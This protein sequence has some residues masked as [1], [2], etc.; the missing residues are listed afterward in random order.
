VDPAEAIRKCR[1]RLYDCHLKDIDSTAPGGKTPE[2]GRG[3]GL[4]QDQRPPA[5]L[6]PPRLATRTGRP[7][8]ARRLR[9]GGCGRG[10]RVSRREG[11][12]VGDV[13]T[14]AGG[15][16]FVRV[17]DPDGGRRVRAVRARSARG[18][19]QGDAAG[20]PADLVEA[21]P[22]WPDRRRRDGAADRFYKDVL[23]FSEIWR[24]GRNGT[25]TDWIKV[26]DGTDYL[27]YMLVTGP[28]DRDRLGSA[29]HVALL[30][31]DIQAALETVRARPKGLDPRSVRT[32]QVGRNR[33]WQ[34]N[35]TSSIPT[36]AAPS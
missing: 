4:L 16:K 25:Q 14:D 29:H 2:A 33:R 30:V 22:R 13:G 36:A 19:R 15:D 32:P 27:E 18:R 31:P 21:P 11:I 3:V 26:P 24:G 12:K 20:R 23:G 34:L 8:L 1:E 17:M 28:V 7:P 35:L 10:A 9:D 6:R 5:R